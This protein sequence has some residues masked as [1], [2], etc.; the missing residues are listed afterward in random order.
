MVGSLHDSI[1]DT[2]GTYSDNPTAKKDYR[3]Q[4][5]GN[6]ALYVWLGYLLLLGIVALV[7]Y[8]SVFGRAEN[9]SLSITQVQFN[10]RQFYQVMMGCLAGLICVITPALTAGAIIG[11]RQRGSLD[12]LFSAP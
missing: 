9:R 10:L 8:D 11:E 4:L 2:F 7:L 6:A 5:R 1:R 12:L 3:A